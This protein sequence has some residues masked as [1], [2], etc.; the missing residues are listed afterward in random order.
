MVPFV[1]AGHF[2]SGIPSEAMRRILAD[3]QI[4]LLSISPE[5]MAKLGASLK[6]SVIDEGT[7]G[8]QR[9]GQLPVETIETRSVLVTSEN[10]GVADPYELTQAIFR[11]VDVI[12][13][14][15]GVETLAMKLPSLPLHPEAERYYRDNGHLPAPPKPWLEFLRATWQGLA[16]MVILAGAYRGLLGLRR[17]TVTQKIERR[18]HDVS[19]QASE[20]DSV[21]KLVEIRHEIKQRVKKRWWQIGE[22][23]RIR[24]QNLEDLVNSAILDAKDNFVRK[25]VVEIRTLP[26][27]SQGDTTSMND[28]YLMLKDQI[29]KH[30]EHGELDPVQH[31]HLLEVLSTTLSEKLEASI[32]A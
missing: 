18:I 10:L 17:D 27:E 21:S 20:P 11:G 13:I 15:G 2:A 29:W 7:Y 32:E 28:H 3:S 31:K 26:E 19:V 1:E 24:W 23:N 16:I 30:F 5:K 4:R 25:I 8:C 22:I 6:M 12:G 14:E 9:K